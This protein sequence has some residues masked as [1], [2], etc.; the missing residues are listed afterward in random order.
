MSVT[1][2]GQ[3]QRIIDE[4]VS[5]GIP[6]EAAKREFEKKYVSAAVM[7]ASGN[8]GRAAKSLGIHRNTLRAKISLL[9]VKPPLRGRDNS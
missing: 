1:I 9:K 5:K 6:L 7:R 3:L 4:L 8:M 2:D